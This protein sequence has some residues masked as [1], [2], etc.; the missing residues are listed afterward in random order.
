MTRGPRVCRTRGVSP[1][2]DGTRSPG[3]TTIGRQNQVI[4]HDY[5]PTAGLEVAA[6]SHLPAE[7]S[8]QGSA[9]VSRE[10]GAVLQEDPHPDGRRKMA[11]LLRHDVGDR[12]ALS[13]HAARSLFR[14][15]L[16]RPSARRRRWLLRHGLVADGLH[17]PR[18]RGRAPREVARH[19][20]LRRP[21]RF[22][23]AG[24]GGDLSGHE[25]RAAGGASVGL[26]GSQKEQRERGIYCPLP[27]PIEGAKISTRGGIRWRSWAH[28]RRDSATARARR[29]RGAG[30]RG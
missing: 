3:A 5:D 29:C 27:V 20:P 15:R 28:R 17:L 4:T 30:S 8:A 24:H 11:R 1:R 23:A 19:L 18:R 21:G 14:H 22:G 6:L 25:P 12:R 7:G 9:L 13:P 10:L 26:Q 2:P 16:A